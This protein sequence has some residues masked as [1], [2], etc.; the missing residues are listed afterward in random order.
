MSNNTDRFLDYEGLK[1]YHHEM[2]ER[3]IDLEFDPNRMFDDK[4]DLFNKTKWGADKYGRVAGL[5]A[6][7]IITVGT[8]IWQLEDPDTFGRI[9]ARV[10]DPNE[11]A[12]IPVEDLGWKIVG[13]NVDFNVVGHTLQ[14]TK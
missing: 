3:L 6:G 1:K 10:Q 13:S 2:V 11:K 12:L 14:L 9:L 8:Q 5:K 7:L 4:V